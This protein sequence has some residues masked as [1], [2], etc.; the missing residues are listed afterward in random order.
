MVFVI[1]MTH[2]A[3]HNLAFSL[4]HTH[5][6]AQFSKLENG[7]FKIGIEN[8]CECANIVT[9]YRNSIEEIENY[10]YIYAPCRFSN[11]I[12]IFRRKNAT[13]IQKFR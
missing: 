2:K 13:N 7:K 9:I 5:T 10:I 8:K 11:R 6:Y 12:S 4:S 1:Q 3:K